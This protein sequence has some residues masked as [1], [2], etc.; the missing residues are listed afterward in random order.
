MIVEKLLLLG[1]GSIM[2]AIL[3]LLKHENHHL[4][5]L[6]AIC[7]C[8]EDIPDD[9]LKLKPDLQHIKAAINE[10][11]VEQLIQ[12]LLDSTVLVIDL[13]VN[14]ETI[15]IIVLCKRAGSMYIN[16]SLEKYNKDESNMDPEKT[17]LYY[18]E[19]CLQN[20]IS[21]ISTPNPTILHSMGMNP[22][23]ISS[24]MYQ[25]IETYCRT[26]RPDLLDAF[27]NGEI[28]KVAS[29]VVDMGHI[30]EYDNQIVNK[31]F[32]SGWMINSWS[33]HG[34]VAEALCTSFISSELPISGYV[35]SKFN[36]RI[37]YSPELKS[38]DCTTNSI[39]LYP[40]GTPFE[41]IG[42]MIT[43][44]EVVSLSEYMALG[45]YVPR[46][47]YVYSSSPISQK[48]LEDILNN[49]YKE[50]SEYYVFNQQDVIN[51]DSF[52]SLGACVYFRDGRKFWCGSVLT[53]NQTMKLL[54][55]K[56]PVNATQLQVAIAILAGI[57]WMLENPERGVITAEEIP[58]KYILQRCIPYW[59]NFFNREI[60]LTNALSTN[61]YKNNYSIPTSLIIDKL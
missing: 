54:G 34:Y 37:Y 39:C 7:I 36:P 56:T 60:I 21:N 26:Y 61:T 24:L 18:Q 35:K 31:E 41:Y 50:P 30:S 1:M 58:H 46:L 25:A 9:I 11:N 52:D 48:C 42:R 57:E 2:R 20:A 22:G 43:H 8:P 3:E 44:F 59:G 29:E 6:P 13:T 49:E 17:T 19:I 16:S 51:K 40:D 28:N 15:D 38:M 47:S 14:V 12:P 23:A 55:S 27:N 45:N 32:K 10:S 53:N 33:S 5:A 4:L